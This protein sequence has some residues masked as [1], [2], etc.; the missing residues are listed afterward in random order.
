M[1]SIGGIHPDAPNG[2]F[3]VATTGGKLLVHPWKVPAI[4]RGFVLLR[5]LV[6]V[7]DL[8]FVAPQKKVSTFELASQ[9]C[10]VDPTLLHLKNDEKDVKL[11]ESEWFWAY[12]LF[13]SGR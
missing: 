2:G 10:W 7:T 12:L 8:L 3:R 1:R 5:R 4:R 13:R 11:T 6:T 9:S